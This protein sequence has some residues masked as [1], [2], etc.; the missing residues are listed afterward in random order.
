[1][2]FHGGDLAMA[3]AKLDDFADGVDFLLGHN[4]IGSYQGYKSGHELN[5]RLL[6]KLTHTRDAWEIV[7]FTEDVAASVSYIRPLAVERI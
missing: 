4:L 3:L 7:N 6:R 5:N 2:V 1:M